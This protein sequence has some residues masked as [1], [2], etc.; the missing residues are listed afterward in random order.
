MPSLGAQRQGPSTYRCFHPQG[1]AGSQQ[2]DSSLLRRL[3]SFARSRRRGKS[4][5][6]RF[7][8]NFSRHSHV[9]MGTGT[10]QPRFGATRWF[11]SSNQPRAAIASLRR[12]HRISIFAIA[13]ACPSA[14]DSFV[15]NGF[16]G[17]RILVAGGSHVVPRLSKSR[18]GARKDQNG[19]HEKRD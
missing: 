3:L 15:R 2:R 17:G 19:Q 11:K 14:S 12:T 5:R 8:A 9:S 7:Y 4:S 1:S 6:L 16:Q 13:K 10:E 18:Y